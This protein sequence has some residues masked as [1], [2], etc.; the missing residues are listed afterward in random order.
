MKFDNDIFK[1]LK[2]GLVIDGLVIPRDPK[3][4]VRLFLDQ[5]IGSN[6]QK[7]DQS[8]DE[9]LKEQMTLSSMLTPPSRAKNGQPFKSHDVLFGFRSNNS[10]KPFLADRPAFIPSIENVDS[11]NIHPMIKSLIKNSFQFYQEVSFKRS[12]L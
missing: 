2:I 7:V 5:K 8:V 10:W 1:P 6:G 11:N 3:D 4:V 9:K 12:F